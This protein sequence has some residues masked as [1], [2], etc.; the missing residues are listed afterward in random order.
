MAMTGSVV[1][2]KSTQLESNYGKSVVAAGAIFATDSK[3]VIASST[4]AKNRVAPSD[5]AAMVT[6]SGAVYSQDGSETLITDCDFVRNEA[7]G[8]SGDLLCEN[9]GDQFYAQYPRTAFVYK[10]TYVPYVDG[11]TSAINPGVLRGKM[12]G[13]CQA[14]PCGVGNACSFTNAS[15]S[16]E[17]CGGKTFSSDGITCRS[18]PMGT[19]PDPEQTGCVPC[20]GNNFSS[21]GVCL[22]CA[23]ALVSDA[24]REECEECGIHRTAIASRVPNRRSACGCQNDFYNS[25]GLSIHVCFG[26]GYDQQIVESA[27]DDH[28]SFT[29]STGQLCEACPRASDGESCLACQGGRLSL[30]AGYTMPSIADA[31]ARRRLQGLPG[32]VVVAV[33][34]CHLEK[35]LA[36]ARCPA[37]N[38][39]VCAPGYEGKLCDSCIAEYGMS[40]A[41]KCEPC[42]DTGYTSKS[43]LVIM[44]I[45]VAILVVLYIAARVWR[46]A[47]KFIRC[48]VRASFQPLRILIT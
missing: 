42:E 15:L 47:E 3:V 18:C 9:C 13:A 29:K 37:G 45:L 26:R 11:Q 7:R 46:T 21:F 41:K 6:G 8:A 2:L 25:S 1:S 12:Q 23:D 17:R 27:I 24:R 33:F 16:C 22:E 38:A 4:L 20:S 5:G 30:R 34:R 10:T 35:E 40:P 19:G 14:N 36:E 44:G 43:F 32:V 28:K 31:N 48:L 39:G